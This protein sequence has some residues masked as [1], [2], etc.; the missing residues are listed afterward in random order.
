MRQTA[1]R[2]F[3]VLLLL[4]AAVTAQAAAKYPPG[5][6]GTCPDT[7]TII[8]CENTLAAC[9]PAILDTV[10]GVGGIITGFDDKPGAYAVYFQTSGGGQFTGIQAFTG[11]FNYKT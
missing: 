10:W 5:P 11:A 9:H 3:G 2:F 7:L 6:G 4:C 8:K 1:T